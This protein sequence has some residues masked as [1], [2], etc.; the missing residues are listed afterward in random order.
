VAARQTSTVLCAWWRRLWVWPPFSGDNGD[1]RSGLQRLQFR[2]NVDNLCG[3]TTGL[4]WVRGARPTSSPNCEL[5]VDAGETRAPGV[6][7]VSMRCYLVE[8]VVVATRRLGRA[9]LGETLD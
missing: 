2:G 5:C 6:M 7:T 3:G 8:G 4:I 9:T 1:G